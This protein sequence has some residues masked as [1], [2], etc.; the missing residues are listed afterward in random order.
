MVSCER[1][2]IDACGEFLLQ[3]RSIRP[4]SIHGF[5]PVKSFV[6]GIK[7]HLN[8]KFLRNRRKVMNLEI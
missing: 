7:R 1:L 8:N 2:T 4:E 3:L 6:A 5:H